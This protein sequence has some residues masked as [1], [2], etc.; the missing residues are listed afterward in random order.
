MTQFCVIRHPEAGLGTAPDTALPH[1]VANGW[2]RVSG[3][4]DA[5]SDLVLSDYADADP[6]DDGEPATTD[7]GELRLVRRQRSGDAPEILVRHPDGSVEPA[8]PELLATPPKRGRRRT[9]TP[10]TTPTP[11]ETA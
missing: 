5:P 11:E 9:A 1:Y 3:W 6:Y 8:P 10:E 2:S 4:A 7:S